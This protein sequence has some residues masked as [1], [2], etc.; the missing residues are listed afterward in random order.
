[1]RPKYKS[2]LKDVAVALIIVISPLSFANAQ[3]TTAFKLSENS[4]Y[5][6]YCHR[7]PYSYCS[8]IEVGD[9]AATPSGIEFIAGNSG[10]SLKVSG[11]VQDDI[12][13]LSVY[14]NVGVIW[15]YTCMEYSPIDN[16][17][18]YAFHNIDS[19]GFSV[20]K[21]SWPRY[22]YT[23][24][25]AIADDGGCWITHLGQIM[26]GVPGPNGV[27][28]IEASAS[29]ITATAN[30]AIAYANRQNNEIGTISAMGEIKRF[31][32]PTANSYVSDLTYGYDGA[33]WFTEKNSLKIG[34]LMH[35]GSIKEYAIPQ[36]EGLTAGPTQILNSPSND[37]L[38]F[39]QGSYLRHIDFEGRVSNEIDTGHVPREMVRGFDGNIWFGALD[40]VVRTTVPTILADIN[41]RWGDISQ[42]GFR[43]NARLLV[44]NSGKKP[45][46]N[47][48]AKVF[49]SK[50]KLMDPT[51]RVVFD[52]RLPVI[53]MQDSLEVFISFRHGRLRTDYM[54]AALDV[55]GSEPEL[56]EKDNL[57]LS[58]LSRR[59]ISK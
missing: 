28:A 41:G 20:C 38:W 7:D 13:S 4:T 6:N 55:D 32:I 44:Q 8:L 26:R 56:N 52:Q 2:L 47:I 37:G 3:E 19:D 1:M 50:D 59:R 15:E 31:Q 35:D 36:I 18:Y 10:T 23:Y 12:L 27:T 24:K 16:T 17:V 29:E 48:R 22:T 53:E 54:I 40:H 42:T 11:T 14:P 21:V 45:T 39:S 34:R 46:G 57:I 30:G 33:V 49:V 25:L 51:D 5:Y 9:L 58:Q 43:V